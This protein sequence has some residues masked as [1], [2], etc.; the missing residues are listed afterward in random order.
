MTKVEKRLNWVDVAKG[1]GM[2]FVILG[3]CVA[4]NSKIHKLIFAFHMP[5]FFLLSGVVYKDDS[6]QS[7]IRRRLKSLIV[8]YMLFCVLGVCLTYL[9]GAEISVKLILKDLY[10]GN[11]ENIWVS[12]VWFLVALFITMVVFSCVLKLH[13]IYAQYFSVLVLAAIGF[14]FGRVYHAGIITH[15]LP[16]DIDV[17]FVSLFFFALG[18]YGKRYLNAFN[19]F[20]NN[21]CKLLCC[22]ICSVAY[23]MLSLLNCRVNLHAIEYGNPILYIAAALLGSFALIVFCQQRM[24]DSIKKVFIWIGKN[25]IYFLG[26]QAIGVRLFIK[27]FNAIIGTEYVLYSLPY[28]Y[29][30]FSFMFTCLFSIM[31]TVIIKRVLKLSWRKLYE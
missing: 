28:K 15:R 17:V 5:F 3:H 9:L 1:V 2:L 23:L 24:N 30:V 6:V 31:F 19:E 29:A 8:P 10:F 16:L 13:N 11:P 21:K 25:N 12:S 14:V 26:A 18:Y 7:I 27:A 20:T 22:A 4:F